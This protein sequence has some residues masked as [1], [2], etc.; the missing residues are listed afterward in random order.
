M[1]WKRPFG[2][3]SLWEVVEFY[4]LSSVI[5]CRWCFVLHKTWAGRCCV[6]ELNGMIRFCLREYYFIFKNQVMLAYLI[7]FTKKCPICGICVNQVSY[8]LIYI[9]TILIEGAS[10]EAAHYDFFV[11]RYNIDIWKSSHKQFKTPMALQ[12]N[13][14]RESLKKIIFTHSSKLTSETLWILF[15]WEKFKLPWNQGWFENGQK[16]SF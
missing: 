10:R 4:V 3:L 5:V 16:L 7:G 6:E 11:K 13:R 14:S 2:V 8:L 9:D 15:T 1:A 12:E